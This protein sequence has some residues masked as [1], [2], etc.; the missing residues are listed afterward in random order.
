MCPLIFN[1]AGIE[2]P[3]GILDKLHGRKSALENIVS[4]DRVFEI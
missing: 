2:Y 3:R 4:Y 1:K